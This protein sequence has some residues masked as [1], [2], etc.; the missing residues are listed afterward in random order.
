[1]VVMSLLREWPQTVGVHKERYILTGPFLGKLVA[2]NGAV[3][4]TREL[5]I[6]T[7]NGR[8]DFDCER[9]YIEYF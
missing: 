1:M 2:L 6:G 8:V 3:Y 4:F 5:A 7:L 9:R